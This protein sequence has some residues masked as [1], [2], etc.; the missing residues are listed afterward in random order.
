VQISI[1]GSQS[2]GN[3]TMRLGGSI[4]CMITDKKL[5]NNT[6]VCN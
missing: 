3:A 1:D 4:I 6:C 2:K 5:T